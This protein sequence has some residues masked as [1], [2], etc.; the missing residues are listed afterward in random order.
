MEGDYLA[1]SGF[2]F[3]CCGRTKEAGRLLDASAAVTTHL[4]SRVLGSFARA[5]V[6]AFDHPNGT[7]DSTLLTEACAA[8]Y[9]TG[10]FDAFVT[11]YRA[12]P[13]LLQ[14]LSD[15][16]V[17]TRPFFHLVHELDNRL[18]ETVGIEAP[19]HETRISG[20]RLTPREREVLDLVR[21]GMSN[22]QIARTLWIA[23]STVKAHV[24]H[25]LEKLG[26]RSRTEAV[27]LYFEEN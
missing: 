6:S 16:R 23:E 25:V 26:V 7:I 4:E 19:S 14:A 22:R 17:D 24:H 5:V 1:T 27:A 8:A 21:Q 11:A 20:E 18:A 9:E 3:A 2:A 15:A 10:N 12:F 13:S